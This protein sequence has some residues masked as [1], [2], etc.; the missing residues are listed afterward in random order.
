MLIQNPR[1][2]KPLAINNT[3]T[4]KSI[5]F[6][7]YVDFSSTRVSYSLIEAKLKRLPSFDWGCGKIDKYAVEQNDTYKHIIVQV[8]RQNCRIA[9]PEIPEQALGGKE[10]KSKIV[11]SPSVP[12]ENEIFKLLRYFVVPFLLTVVV[13]GY[14]LLRF[15]N[16]PQHAVSSSGLPGHGD[17]QAK[18]TFT[19]NG[20]GKSK[21]KK[22]PKA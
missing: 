12:K 18:N 8:R 17:I 1:L 3:I 11:E 15:L 13:V 14:S 6:Y 9:R 16:Y 5:V 21:K 2:K 20:I 22:I 10:N 4:R 7:T 19:Q